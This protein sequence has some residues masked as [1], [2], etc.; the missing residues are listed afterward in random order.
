MRFGWS[1]QSMDFVAL[2]FSI[3]WLSKLASSAVE[4][5]T[6]RRFSSESRQNHE[7]FHLWDHRPTWGHATRPPPAA[8]FNISERS[9]NVDAIVVG[10]RVCRVGK[11]ASTIASF[12]PRTATSRI[13]AAQIHPQGLTPKTF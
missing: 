8:L 1:P 7:E 13:A 5:E 6:Y 9:R 10:R 2:L 12:S 11:S 4:R 3:H